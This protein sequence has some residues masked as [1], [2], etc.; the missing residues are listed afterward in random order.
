MKD[1]TEQIE[2]HNYTV[3]TAYGTFSR[4]ETVTYPAVPGMP[5]VWVKQLYDANG[6]LNEVQRADGTAYWKAKTY[7]AEGHIK[8]QQLGNGIVTDRVC[9]PET[10][11]LKAIQSGF[12]GGVGVQ[13]L[14]YEFSVI[15]NLRKRTDH[16]QTVNGATLSEEFEYDELNRS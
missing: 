14:E 4:P 3:S 1:Q 7:D 2:A 5:G 13:N 6:Y 16:N 12:N 15:G 11:V 9:V 8:Q 10:G